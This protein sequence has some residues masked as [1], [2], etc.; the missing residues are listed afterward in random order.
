MK[1]IKKITINNKAL[2]SAATT[3]IYVVEGDPGAVFSLT[4]T[5]ED[6]HFYNFPE[7]TIITN[8]KTQTLV[9]PAFSAD[10]V[11]LSP[12][13]IGVDGVYAG[14]ITFPIVTDDDF[15]QITLTAESHYDT[16]ISD[17]L[18]L[19]DVYV[20]PKITQFLDTTVTFDLASAEQD[21]GDESYNNYPSSVA[22]AGY[23][24]SVGLNITPVTFALVWPVTLSASNFVILRQPLSSDFKFT[25]TK[26]TRTAGSSS[27]SLELTDISGLSVGMVVSGTGI[28]GGATVTALT[29]GYYDAGKSTVARPFYTIPKVLNALGN[30]L[31]DDKGGTVTLSADSTFVVNRTITFSGSGP[32]ASQAFNDTRFSVSNFKVVIDDVVTTT[33]AAVANSTTIPVSSTAG[34]KDDVSTVSGIGIDNEATI[35]ITNISSLNLTASAAQTIENGQTLIFKVASRSAKITADVTILEYGNSNITLTLDLDNILSVE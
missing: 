34:I 10:E 19:K 11:R 13:T 3:R 4:V 25:T 1:E 21:A 31:Q 5:N 12:K 29:S 14:S 7:N 18:S 30:G 6:N 32:R 33:S 8:P 15:Y 27:K 35:T 9:A 17:E 23:D 22:K 16:K 24:S 26:T 2:P 20:L 28:A